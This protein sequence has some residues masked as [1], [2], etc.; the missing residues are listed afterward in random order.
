MN[1]SIQYLWLILMVL[2]IGL[3]AQITH[4]GSPIAF[5]Q[6]LIP[7]QI[8]QIDNTELYFIDSS[9]SKDC[10]AMEFARFLDFE[11][12]L[13]DKSWTINQLEN[14]ANLYRLAIESKGALALG[15]Y[16]EDVYIPKGAKMFVYDPDLEEF[17]GAYTSENNKASGF[18]NPELIKGDQIV[19][20]YYEPQAVRGEGHMKLM[21]V[22]HAYRPPF[23]ETE[24]DFGDSGDCEVN[25]NCSEGWGKSNQRDA[26][27][28]LLI[29]NGNSG[30]WCTGSLINNTSMDKTPYVLTADHCGKYSS[31]SDM[32]QWR[33]YFN[34]QSSDCENP[35]AQPTL[36]TLIG[37][38]KIAA[39]SN[40]D[41]LG[42][43]F[44]L[45]KI[46][47]DIPES[48]HSF[49]IGWN[50]D[51]LGSN[52]GYTIHHPQGDI[53]KISIYNEALKSA[54]YQNGIT[55]AHWEVSWVETAH[56]HG[57]TEGGSSGSPIFDNNGYIIGTLTGG[58]ASCSAL[59][60]PDYYGKFSIHWEGNGTAADEQLAPW[61][62]PE[63]TGQLKLDGVYLDIDELNQKS[64]KN[65]TL[66]PNPA[67]D[68]VEIKFD[69]PIQ[70]VQV[71]L[72]L[73]NGQ[74]LHTYYFSESSSINI[75]NLP[76]GVYLVK[77]IYEK[78]SFVEKLVKE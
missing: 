7:A 37:C 70:N 69:E 78:N 22:L 33:F 27:L 50:R 3:A 66:I 71:D 30:T 65:F 24:K 54:T 8:T 40:A 68:F 21:Q 53:K 43:D 77:V 62:D 42:S 47:N 63:N 9:Y 39:S 57:V 5:Q 12:E 60:S 73:I 32:L 1:K 17:Y 19:L 46:N 35:E 44:F 58:Q 23:V 34:Y 41:I 18:F 25:V 76:K 52:N 61:L 75:S 67:H 51:G 16:F 15:L 36:R 49:F 4:G 38:E 72:I 10:S 45:V 26:V 48:Y 74:L 14:G 59:T 64:Q 20:E 31:E 13:G 55:G 6:K 56:G 28:R 11:S 29:K 2:P